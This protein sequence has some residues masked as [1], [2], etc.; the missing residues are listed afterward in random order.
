MLLTG[1]SHTCSS[2]EKMA[3]ECCFAARCS[4]GGCEMIPFFKTIF[5]LQCFFFSKAGRKGDQE[6]L[7]GRKIIFKQFQ[8]RR[9]FGLW[10]FIS[11]PKSVMEGLSSC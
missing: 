4:S 9:Q 7:L 1:E 11:C 6:G 5:I 8:T 10:N 3:F 2:F